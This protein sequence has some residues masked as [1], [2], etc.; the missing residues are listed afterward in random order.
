M[1]HLEKL[2]GHKCHWAVCM[3]HTNELPLRH[4]IQ[5]IDGP[6]TSNT[7]FSGPIGKLLYRVNLM[8]FNADFTP[9]LDGEPMAEMPEKVLRNMSTDQQLSFRLCKALK[10]GEL[11]EN[12]R[13]IQCGPM[14]HTRWLTIGCTYGR[15]N[16]N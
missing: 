7:G 2:L 11:P 12:L 13:E 6:T 8:E 9:I 4:L 10:T 16:M 14:N 15:G 3:L 5:E 1:A